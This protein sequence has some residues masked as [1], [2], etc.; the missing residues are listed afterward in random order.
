VHLARIF[1]TAELSESSSADFSAAA[2]I[3]P[4]TM[5]NISD[6]KSHLNEAKCE[7]SSSERVGS[8]ILLR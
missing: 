7:I 5:A 2:R 6:D 3:L 4:S 8:G 1:I